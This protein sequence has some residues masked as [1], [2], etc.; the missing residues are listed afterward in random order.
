MLLN[1][2]IRARAAIQRAPGKLKEFLDSKLMEFDQENAKSCTWNK[3]VPYL[4]YQLE[5]ITPCKYRLQTGWVAAVQPK[6]CKV[7]QVPRD[8]VEHP[9]L[10]IFRSR[11]GRALSII[12]NFQVSLALNRNS[13]KIASRPKLLHD[14]PEAGEA[15]DMKSV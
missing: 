9:P 11:V 7:A 1:T 6:G 3:R 10:Q 8:S 12:I 5:K 15:S 14:L 13:K 4:D 2:F